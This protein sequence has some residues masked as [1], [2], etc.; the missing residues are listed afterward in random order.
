M[1][2]LFYKK[3]ENKVGCPALFLHKMALKPCHNLFALHQQKPIPLTEK[4]FEE[5]FKVKHLDHLFF[6]EEDSFYFLKE[7]TD[8]HLAKP[9]I[10]QMKL[11]AKA[12]FSKEY[13]L[14]AHPRLLIKKIDPI[15]GLGVVAYQNIAAYSY[16]GE[17]TGVVRKRSKRK[18]EL[19]D[20]VFGFPLCNKDSP[21]S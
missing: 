13:H 7:K 10:R 16:I 6:E 17:Y 8:K 1:L 18:D 5:Y 19:N 21:L 11:W 2:G 15:M 3:K 20:Y 9:L 12:M 14:Q 4:L